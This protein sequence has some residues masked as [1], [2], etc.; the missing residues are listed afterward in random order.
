MIDELCTE[1]PGGLQST[2]SQEADVTEATYCTEHKKDGHKLNNQ[3]FFH[4]HVTEILERNGYNQR[5]LIPAIPP[6]RVSC[7]TFAFF[8]LYLLTLLQLKTID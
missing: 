4:M 6:P 2:G 1:E 5:E 8:L 3:F 7:Q